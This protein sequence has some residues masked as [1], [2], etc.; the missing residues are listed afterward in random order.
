M[1]NSDL[2]AIQYDRLLDD[3]ETPKAWCFVI[4]GKTMYL[5]KSQVED[6]RE[7][8]KVVLVP[9]WLAKAKKL[10]VYEA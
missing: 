7:T 5:P 2:I 3:R 4:D 10:E 9:L 8:E 1:D 6:I